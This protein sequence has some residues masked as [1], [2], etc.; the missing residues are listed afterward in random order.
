MA[1]I[2]FDYECDLSSGFVMD[3]NENK[4]FGYVTA[5]DGFGLP[6]QLKQDLT[7]AVPYNKGGSPTFG[8]PINYKRTAGSP[9]GTA[10]VVGV[11]KQF[12]WAGGACDPIKL[13]FYASQGNAMQILSLQHNAL[14]TTDIKTLGWWIADYDQDTKEWFEQAHPVSSSGGITGHINGREDP[15]LEVDLNPERVKDNV[16]VFVYKVTLE[17]VPAGKLRH[18]LHFA[19][20]AQKK[21]IRKWGVLIGKT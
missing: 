17:V 21:L 10:S 12:H 3:P 15:V 5:L 4:R 2:S 9:T 18:K 1:N 8:A 13:E 16:D 7:V 11:L 19:S 20:S 6:E 14:K